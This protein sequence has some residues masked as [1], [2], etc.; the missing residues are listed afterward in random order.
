M[1]KKSL[2]PEHDFPK[3]HAHI[4]RIMALALVTTAFLFPMLLVPQAGQA[5]SV[6][7]YS[8]GI[9]SATADD[10]V[11]IMLYR[12]RPSSSVSFHTKAVPILLF[13]G[14]IENMNQ[15]L[16]C[17]PTE[18][19]NSYS[20]LT[21]P[22]PVAS[23]ATTKNVWGQTV[24]EKYIK[25]D[26]MKYYS[27]AHY[28]WLQGYDVWLTNYRDTGRLNMRSGDGSGNKAILNTLDTWATLDAPAA[29]A[30]VQAVTGKKIFIGGHSTA[31]M[32]CYAYLQGCY[33]DYDNQPTK[34]L[35]VY[36]AASNAGYQRHVKAD[37]QLSLQRN[38]NIRGV[39]GLDPA[40]RPPLP[41]YLDAP[42]VWYVMC[43]KYY[44]PLD[45]ASQSLFQ[46]FPTSVVCTVEQVFFGAI[47]TW[48][49]IFSL[50]GLENSLFGYLD[51]WY[52]KDTDRYVQD[53]MARYGLSGVSV[54][55][56]AHYMDNGLHQTTREF[57]MNGI[58]NKNTSRGPEPAP[59]SDGYYYYSEN[60]GRFAVPLIA[61]LSDSGSLV[62]P[63]NAYEDII[64][65]KTPTPLDEWY[66]I[67]GTAHV[68]LVLGKKSPGEVFP[69][70]GAW[71]KKVIA[72]Q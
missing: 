10:G 18:M 38:A 17:T 70:V 63:L 61:C 68:D 22:N 15:Y 65:K 57:W 16:S 44:I 9:Y 35:A 6:P 24:L 33:M 58:E 60:M 55:G 20:N 62:T 25:D 64:S 28:L 56:F 59:G 46:L 42:I 7:Y 34:K 5:S 21:L 26:P 54:R 69:K 2:F 47:N 1:R 30:K 45:A 12:Y 36:K 50:G 3:L 37:L 49:T 11:K 52:M 32:V 39:I 41:S 19:K 71:L 51:F 66:V 31:G 43:S 40:G 27:L 53:F 8:S 67:T 48:D 23:W 13:T 4:K 72:A 14:I 29:I